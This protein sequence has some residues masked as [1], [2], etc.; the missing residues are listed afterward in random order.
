M[1]PEHKKA[2][3]L[4]FHL[5]SISTVFSQSA[6]SK[7]TAMSIKVINEKVLLKRSGRKYGHFILIHGLPLE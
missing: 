2:T 3:S 7:H 1:C 5:M 6:V 4:H